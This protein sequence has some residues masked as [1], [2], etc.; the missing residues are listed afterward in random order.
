MTLKLITYTHTF[1]T[2]VWQMKTL[3]S[4]AVFLVVE[5]GVVLKRS[6]AEITCFK[7]ILY[8]E[9]DALIAGLSWIIQNVEDVHTKSLDVIFCG[10][11]RMK[12]KRDITAGSM[13]NDYGYN[14]LMTLVQEF[15]TVSYAIQG[16][17]IDDDPVYDLT[18]FASKVFELMYGDDQSYSHQIISKD[19]ATNKMTIVGEPEIHWRNGSPQEV[20]I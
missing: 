20:W 4:I 5:D 8:A 2:Y 16:K 7:D 15:N 17:I 10:S 13:L 19:E 6:A 9:I 1:N 14:E 11:A 3:T 18:T 12:I